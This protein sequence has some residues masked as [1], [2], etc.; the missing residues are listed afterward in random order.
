MACAYA[1]V[2]V[3]AAAREDYPVIPYIVDEV[4]VSPGDGH[5]EALKLL[6]AAAAKAGLV[7]EETEKSKALAK[8]LGDTYYQRTPRSFRL[9][10]DP[11]TEG[12][13]TTPDALRVVR[14]AKR[15]AAARMKELADARKQG[16]SDEPEVDLRL[17]IAI[18]HLLSAN[19]L[20]G[21][22]PYTSGHGSGGFAP[23]TSG[24]GGGFAP[25]TSG[26]GGGLAPY[27]SGH[28]LDT[29]GVVGLGAR[30]PVNWVGPEPTRTAVSRRP[31]VVTLDTGV[32]DHPWL[33]AV[34]GVTKGLQLDD[35]TLG[36]TDPKT[37]PEVT[38]LSRGALTGAL[39]SH[40]GHGTFIAGLIRQL[41]PDADIRAVRVMHGNGVADEYELLRCL[42][43]LAELVER[44]Q[45]NEETGLAVDIIVMS[46][47]YQHET[48]QDVAYDRLM[49]PVLRKLGSLGVAV[50]TAAGNNAWDEAVFPAAFA[51]HE[52]GSVPEAEHGVV[53]VTSVGSRNPNG[54]VALF[55]NYGDWVT[56]WD[57]GAALV[58]SM[59]TTFNGGAMPL[60]QF[61]GDDGA[62]RA[63]IDLDDFS[64]GYG[65]WSGT[66]FA[67]PAFAGRLARRL[68]DDPRFADTERRMSPAEVSE[69]L[70]SLAA[71]HPL[72]PSGESYAPDKGGSS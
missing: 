23:Y 5:E 22:A 58:S 2:T 4:I 62:T 39:D 19:S 27:T 66:S 51:P 57:S 33:R 12:I 24:H 69:V 29:Y 35:V 60:V 49:L 42:L 30:Q 14:R 67:A 37:D 41:C 64:A 63:T 55:S 18:N 53:P 68:L 36:F 46:L 11:E 9:V 28:G 61:V 10:D 15:L 34:D 70:A 32:G 56:C 72:S 26:H 7:A 54:T 40:S 43:A 3:S 20:L 59:P 48:P 21:N 31:V 47:G 8:A 6:N 38:G 52:G 16:Q 25:Y 44:N 17:M 1:S 65:V 45:E 71:E 13:D 50:V